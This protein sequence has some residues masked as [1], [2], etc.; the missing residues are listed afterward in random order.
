MISLLNYANRP[1]LTDDNES[2]TLKEFDVF[3]DTVKELDNLPKWA[4]VQFGMKELN[5]HC[6][7]LCR[8]DGKVYTP[9]SFEDITET[10]WNTNGSL[11]DHGDGTTYAV[12]DVTTVPDNFDI[13]RLIIGSL[14]IGEFELKRD[15]PGNYTFETDEWEVMITSSGKGSV[16]ISKAGLASAHIE[17]YIV[18]KEYT[19]TP[20]G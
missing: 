9:T 15:T 17:I 13:C 6:S 1:V 7:A 11:A 20:I 18:T 12:Q 2:G 4:R 19:W 5:K 10:I 3:T 8:E 16:V 14:Q